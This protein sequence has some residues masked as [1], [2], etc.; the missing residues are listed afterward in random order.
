MGEFFLYVTFQ[1]V[2]EAM[3]A[4]DVFHKTTLSFK[5]VPVPRQISSHCGVALLFSVKDKKDVEKIA[6]Q[7]G[8]SIEEF[9]VL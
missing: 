2:H 7:K 6:V 8:L 1:S 9:H 3:K 5:V 4:E